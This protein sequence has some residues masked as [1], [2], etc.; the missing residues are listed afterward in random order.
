MKDTSSSRRRS[1]RGIALVQILLLLVALLLLVGVGYLIFSQPAEA[2][3]NG[4]VL[5]SASPSTSV[6]TSQSGAD[7][8][9]AG[10]GSSRRIT[11][12]PGRSDNGVAAQEA[13]QGLNQAG[14]SAAEPKEPEALSGTVQGPDVEPLVL[15][16]QAGSSSPLFAGSGPELPDLNTSD[17]AFRSALSLLDPSKALLGWLIDEELIRKF[18]V[19]VDNMADGKLPRKHSLLRPMTDKFRPSSR[20]D[21]LWLD[22]YNYSRYNRY[23]ELVGSIDSE[24]WVELYRR[25]Y[26]LMQQAYAELGYPRKSFH[27]R[28]LKALDHLLAAPIVPRALAL[29]QPSVMYIYAEP[30]LEQLSAVHKQ[31]LRVGP[32]NAGQV[33][34]LASVLR[35][36]LGKLQ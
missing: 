17:N 11:V 13:N 8:L 1:G 27:D 32:V 16:Q 10:E 4:S 31:M 33:M 15:G 20:E 29:A 12:S 21:Q 25:Y 6:G 35:L 34:E 24:R 18:V 7:N 2:P 5:D 23:V 22:G 19:T 9:A 30:E 3:L 14:P 28:M 36:E 26:P